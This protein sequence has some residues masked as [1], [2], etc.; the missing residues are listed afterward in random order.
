MWNRECARKDHL[1]GIRAEKEDN[2]QGGQGAAREQMDL[3]VS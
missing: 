3:V 2:S 1:G